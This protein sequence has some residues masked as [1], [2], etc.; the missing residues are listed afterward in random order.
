MRQQPDCIKPTIEWETVHGHPRLRVVGV[1]EVGRGCLAGPVVAGAVILPS[2]ID[3]SAHPWL[4]E[5]TDSKELSPQARERLAPLI[6]SWVLAWGVGEASVEEIDRVNIYHAA[7]LAMVRAVDALAL[8][9]DHALIDGNAIPKGLKCTST[10]IVKGDLQCLSIAAGSI[11]AK[12]HRDRLMA[13]L[14][15]RYPG[16]GFGAHKGYSTPTHARAL[17]SLGAC[18]IHR[19]SFAPVAAVLSASE[20]TAVGENLSLFSE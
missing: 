11:I 7:H 10:A 2:E 13:Q 12:V 4:S 14:D 5:I 16:Y 6:R 3:F 9:P 20:V 15:A 19:R 8:K 17:K 18:E 1:D